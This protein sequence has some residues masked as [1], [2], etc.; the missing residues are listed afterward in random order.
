M[1]L[2]GDKEYFKDIPAI[3]YEGPKSDNPLAF[4]YYNPDQIV[5]GKLCVSILNLLWHIG[6]HSVDKALIRLVLEHRI[7]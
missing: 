5:A 4:K 6:I 2:K 7:F 1:I 3:K